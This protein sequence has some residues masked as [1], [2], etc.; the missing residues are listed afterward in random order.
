MTDTV[1]FMLGNL[2]WVFVEWL[3]I[4]YLSGNAKL[5]FT[6]DLPPLDMFVYGLLWSGMAVL[7]VYNNGCRMCAMY[8]KLQP[9]P[10]QN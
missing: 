4:V 6:S 7:A 5:A 9:E 10:N 3:A 2:F 1:F 8:Q